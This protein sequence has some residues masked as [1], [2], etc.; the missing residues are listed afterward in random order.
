MAIPFATRRRS[1]VLA[2]ILIGLCEM[3]ALAQR[4]AA[5]N[6]PRRNG[7]LPPAARL[8]VRRA[9]EAVGLIFVRNASDNPR[10]RPRGSGVVIRSDGVLVTNFHVISDT[11]VKR[12]FD[13]LYL[14]LG[15]DAA[16]TGQP[17]YRLEPLVVNREYDLALLRVRADSPTARPLALTALEL[18]DSESVH[19]LDDLVIIGYPEK[20]G[21]SVTLSPGVVEGRDRLGQWIKTDARVIHGNSGG[22][23]ITLDGKL[24]GIPTKVEADVQAIDRDGDGFPDT[25]RTFG[26]VGFLRPAHL[27]AALL[28]E[29]E[30]RQSRRFNTAV[31]AAI[32][33]AAL[34]V[35]GIVR[36][37]MTGKLVAG[38]LVGLLPVGTERVTEE[39]LL[40]W[41]SANAEGEF[42]LNR[43]VPPGRYTLKVR[44]L[45][46][47]PYS[48]DVEIKAGAS[49]LLIE[50]REPAK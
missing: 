15:D 36:S 37:Q 5:P 1:L 48:R 19:L 46:Y 47:T 8:R 34:N 9:V 40:A 24:V 22:A 7:P 2:I 41:G 20:G 49:D 45:G 33:P 39:S 11:Q 21:A 35:R 6:P 42:K 26:A 12:V 3:V 43:P 10:P 23:A 27:V 14:A 17:Q 25:Q 28:A 50:L 30:A 18:G 31:P 16:T 13:E 44:A 29:A 38:A 4:P 32:A